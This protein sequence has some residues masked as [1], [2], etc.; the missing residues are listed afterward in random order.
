MAV[1]SYLH[2]GCNW[3]WMLHA[4][5]FQNAKLKVLSSLVLVCGSPSLKRETCVL[6]SLSQGSGTASISLLISLCTVFPIP[7]HPHL[8]FPSDNVLVLLL[9]LIMWTLLSTT[10]S[11]DGR[12]VTTFS[13]ELTTWVTLPMFT[14]LGPSVFVVF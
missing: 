1:A 8:L 10:L 9:V 14:L 11:S 12:S 3:L 2:S 13:A 6:N 7:L 5:S 4:E